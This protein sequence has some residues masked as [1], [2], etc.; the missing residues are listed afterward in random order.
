MA[1]PIWALSALVNAEGYTQ[2]PSWLFTSM[3][4]LFVVFGLVMDLLCLQMRKRQEAEKLEVYR[5]TVW[6]AHHVL[7]NFLNKLY[8]IQYRATENGKFTDELSESMS[9]MIQDA[10]SQLMVLSRVESVDADK[11]RSS[12]AP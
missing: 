5:A 2:I 11:I 6:G 10:A 9:N 7:N 12:V 8:L 1:L 4:G 3:W